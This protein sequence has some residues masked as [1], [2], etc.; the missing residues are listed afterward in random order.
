MFAAVDLTALGDFLS[1]LLPAVSNAD[2]VV[3]GIGAVV[4]FVIQIAGGNKVNIWGNI[5]AVL[6]KIGGLV[7][8][9]AP[10]TPASTVASAIPSNLSATESAVI[11]KVIAGITA[12]RAAAASQTNAA[13]TS[14]LGG[15]LKDV[16][17]GLEGAVKA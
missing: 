15:V 1:S 6:G 13:Q 2:P 17:A 4:L 12:A 8:P 7:S 5:K 14:L 16:A 9:A 3:A 11:Q 10:V